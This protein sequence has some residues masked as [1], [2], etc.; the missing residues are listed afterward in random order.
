MQ[1][2]RWK[3][4]TEA[5]IFNMKQAIQPRYLLTTLMLIEKLDI[6][7]QRAEEKKEIE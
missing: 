6:D 7:K 5:L 2:L 1:N 4:E 3:F